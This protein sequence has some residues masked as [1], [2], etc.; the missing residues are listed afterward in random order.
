MALLC[1]IQNQRHHCCLVGVRVVQKVFVLITHTYTTALANLILSC[2]S[3][4]GAGV[5]VYLAPPPP[6]EQLAP[7]GQAVPGYLAPT[8]VTF[9]PRGQAVQA[10]LSCP[11]PTQVN[12][13]LCYFVIFLYHYNEFRSY[14]SLKVRN[15]CLW[16]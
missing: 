15:W 3:T 6:P 12:I 4:K 5:T 1:G 9:T 14:T 11:P 10:S 16:G 8:L 2:T 13:Y 7:G